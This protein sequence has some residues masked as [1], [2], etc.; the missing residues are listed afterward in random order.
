MTKLAKKITE[1]LISFT[2]ICYPFMWDSVLKDEK[3]EIISTFEGLI[4]ANITLV[5]KNA[6]R[7][8]IEIID[9]PTPAE[10]ILGEAPAKDGNIVIITTPKPNN[11]IYDTLL[12]D[13][14]KI[15]KERLDMLDKLLAK[16]VKKNKD[17]W[18]D[19]KPYSKLP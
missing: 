6:I 5:V 14:K 12:R 3:E 13:P 15:E 16:D 10:A 17:D 4:D 9:I 7:E 19:Y 8:A 2:E 11:D 18:H 1:E